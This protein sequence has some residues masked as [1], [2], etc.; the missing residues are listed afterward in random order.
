MIEPTK[1]TT[2]T[3]AED[4]LPDHLD[5]AEVAGIMVRKGTV[6]AF[7]RNAMKWSDPSTANSERQDLER[8]MAGSVE[9]LRVLGVLT[10]FEIRDERLRA[11]IDSH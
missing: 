7:V 1:S 9:A 4:V 6:A 10:V 8:E 2:V 11:F 5:R 3:R